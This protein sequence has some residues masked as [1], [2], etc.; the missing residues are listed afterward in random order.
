MNGPLLEALAKAINYHDVECIEMFR[1]GAPLVGVG[2]LLVVGCPL[3]WFPF[4]RLG[5]YPLQVMG[6]PTRCWML[7]SVKMNCSACV[8]T[9]IA[10]CLQDC[11]R[12]N[13]PSSYCRLCTFP[14][15]IL[16]VLALVLEACR[17]DAACGRMTA[18]RELTLEDLVHA[19]LSP[20]FGVEQG[21]RS[22]F[23][24][25]VVLAGCVVVPGLM[26]DG[27]VKVR[28]ID[29]M[30]ASMVNAATC[31][32]EKV[33]C[34]TLDLFFASM[35]RLK[36]LDDG[37]TKLWKAD[38][39]SAF[40]RIPIRVEH[41]QY[42]RIVMQVGAELLTAQHLTMMFGSVGSVSA[43]HRVGCLLRA[44]AR[45]LLM[46]PVLT[47]VDDY[48]AID[49][50]Q[51]A[52]GA[53]MLFAR[54]VRLC[55]GL[56]SVADRKLECGNPLVV[57]GVECALGNRGVTFWPSADK[58]QKWIGTMVRILADMRMTGGEASKLSGQLQ[59]ASQSTFSKL[60]RALLRPII[61]HIHA[62]SSTVTPQLATA[63]TWWL[64]V[65]QLDLRTTRSWFGNAG[66]Q[67][68]LFSDARS[69]PP[70]LGAVLFMCRLSCV[71]CRQILLSR[72]L[73]LQ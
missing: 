64:D 37:P 3:L 58:V 20:R 48:F 5:S 29:D 45:R 39:D 55:L 42:A 61:D 35:R 50:E 68:H 53:M 26:P 65:L 73:F 8:T 17:A 30:S 13:M 27:S 2:A 43:W 6:L 47:Y 21:V 40:R 70:R 22:G 31:A 67:V 59:W 12:I 32:R 38:V 9:S 10:M 25:D 71:I 62:R 4:V 16:F 14:A 28:P 52:A 69:T 72:C 56:S 24:L 63:L 51:N 7:P 23:L 57:L 15:T 18:P 11:A 33:S 49:R 46:L 41:R 34:D 66:R 44:L 19:N 54:L 60:G 1:V 36:Q